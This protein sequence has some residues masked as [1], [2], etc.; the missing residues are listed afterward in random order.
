MGP[1]GVTERAI[2][3]GAALMAR[4]DPERTPEQHE[5]YVRKVIEG[6]REHLVQRHLYDAVVREMHGKKEAQ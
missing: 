6:I 2:A 1:N 3:Q 4:L 5:Q